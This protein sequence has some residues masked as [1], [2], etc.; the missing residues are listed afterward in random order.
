MTNRH[1]SS[2]LVVAKGLLIEALVLDKTLQKGLARDA[3]RLESLCVEHG[4]SVFTLLLPAGCKVLD[5]ALDTGFLPP[6]RLPLFGGV[7]GTIIPRLFQG[8]WLKVFDS[9]GC[10]KASIDPTFVL[11]L[12]SLLLLGSK[13]N[14]ACAPSRVYNTTEEFFHVESSLP[15]PNSDIW[16]SES[17]DFSRVD[18]GSLLDLDQ[19]GFSGSGCFIAKLAAIDRHLLD[20]CQRVADSVASSLGS[21]EPSELE[22][23]HG[24]GATAEAK[25]GSSYKYSFPTWSSRLDA[26]FPWDLYGISSHGV[27]GLDNVQDLTPD[28]VDQP[29]R[30][31]TVPK[32]AK[33]PRL[34]AAEPTANMYIQQGIANLLVSRIDAMPDSLGGSIKFHNQSISGD[35]A[36][37]ASKK[38]NLATV[39]LKSASDRLSCWLVQRLF[40]GNLSLLKAASS[41][42]TRYLRNDVDKKHPTVIE[43]RKFATMGSALTFPVQS[44]SFFVLAVSATLY[45]EWHK[46]RDMSAKTPTWKDVASRV[47]VYGDDIIL[48]VEALEHLERLIA[49]VGLAVNRG[50][51]FGGKNFRESCGVDGFQGYDVTPVKPRQFPVDDEPA[52][53][54]AAIDTAN[55]FHSKGLWYAAAAVKSLV[56]LTDDQVPLVGMDVG[57]WGDKSYAAS[58]PS[59][60]AEVRLALRSHRTRWNRDLHRH[61]YLVWQP[62]AVVRRTR[63]FEGPENLLQYFLEDPS[64]QILTNWQSGV[65]SVSDAALGLR[66]VAADALASAGSGRG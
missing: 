52:S 30:L 65:N 28:E 43:L 11:I 60:D 42:R 51:T 2:L 4:D 6:I 53:I 9:S 66:W 5:Q 41:S 7:G 20:T 24:P 10:L 45:A 19:P 44:L 22:F 54:I 38:R 32:T 8:I 15:K 35:L 27:L 50:K 23:K 55:L 40:R 48:P 26:V 64:G 3:R 46:W 1:V 25:R 49:L 58:N 21:F 57:T 16:H 39:D 34:I 62:K 14:M 56:R 13:V 31:L 61:E 63:R 59:L 18:C 37:S 12:R 36:L 47:Q 33:G 17:L 29:S